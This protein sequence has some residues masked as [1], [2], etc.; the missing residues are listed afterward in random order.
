M[1]SLAF[2]RA[3][4]VASSAALLLIGA[5]GAAFASPSVSVATSASIGHAILTDDQG[6]TLYHLTRD[7]NGTSTCYDACATA[8]PPI[9]VDAV[10][11]VQDPTLAQ[12]LGLS[13]RN[14]GTQQLT[15]AGQPLYHYVGDSQ[16]GDTNGQGSGGV[17]FVV[18]APVAGSAA[19]TSS[20][21]SASS[22]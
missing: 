21:T 13:P 18:D 17:W 10:P 2:H 7:Q 20:P 8:W 6:M 12:R 5:A 16:P 11:N 19:A 15:Y 14:D 22:Y 4:V 1:L 3:A 9:V